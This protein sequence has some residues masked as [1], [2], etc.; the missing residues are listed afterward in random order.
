MELKIVI[1]FVLFAF[2][3]SS[4]S[5][6]KCN[7]NVELQQNLH[8][9]G[10]H[11]NMTYIV[12]F[13]DDY[14]IWLNQNCV[15]A[16]EQELPPGVY[17]HPNELVNL[18]KRNKAN[19]FLKKHVDIEAL[20]EESTNSYVYII[21]KVLKNKIYVYLPLHGRYHAA[22]QGGGTVKNY[23][24]SPTLYL[25]CPDNRLHDCRD[26]LPNAVS[27]L[28]YDKSKKS[29][30]WKQI[31]YISLSEAIQ[32]EVPVGNTDSTYMVLAGTY[33]AILTGTFFILDSLRVYNS[34]SRISGR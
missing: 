3:Y 6:K 15:M 13:H 17:A 31:P 10:F 4:I 14:E 24:E 19:I 16:L 5:K 34:Q 33:L 20:A 23:F 28:C 25:R 27:F 22:R 26:I 11:R 18:R 9:T 1:L 29:C 32:W 8:N 2:P 12:S 21:S 30:D 7:F